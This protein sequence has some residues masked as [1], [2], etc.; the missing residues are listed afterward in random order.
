MIFPLSPVPPGEGVAHSAD[1]D[2]IGEFGVLGFVSSAEVLW[3]GRGQGLKSVPLPS[4]G[5][6]GYVFQVVVQGGGDCDRAAGYYILYYVYLMMFYAMPC[7][8]I[9]SL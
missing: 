2:V 3:Q 1:V 4:C 6:V 8:T 9:F 5:R 7:R